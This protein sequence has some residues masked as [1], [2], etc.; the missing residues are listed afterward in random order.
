MQLTSSAPGQAEMQYKP[1]IPEN[2]LIKNGGRGDAA[3]QLVKAPQN[4]LEKAGSS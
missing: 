2:F 3:S 4:K 1:K